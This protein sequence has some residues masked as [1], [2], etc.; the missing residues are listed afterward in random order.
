M[1]ALI[2]E[3]EGPFAGCLRFMISFF[4]KEEVLK[5][6]LLMLLQRTI[7]QSNEQES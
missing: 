1:A 5:L 2:R 4:Y 6:L 7:V 3:K